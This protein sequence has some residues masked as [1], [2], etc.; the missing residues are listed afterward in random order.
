MEGSGQMVV[1]V[2]TLY[3]SVTTGGSIGHAR[4]FEAAGPLEAN[5]AWV[6]AG[7]AQVGR[8]AAR[9][10]QLQHGVH[11]GLRA[12]PQNR[13]HT[14]QIVV[15]HARTRLRRSPTKVERQRVPLL[16]R[17]CPRPSD[18]TERAR[19]SSGA[20][21]LRWRGGGWADRKVGDQALQPREL[22]GGEVHEAVDPAARAFTDEHGEEV[23]ARPAGRRGK[24]QLRV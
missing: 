7:G 1:W 24:G 22:L 20:E 12:Q 3:F 14:E 19:L 6:S 2:F 16:H 13:Q 10:G 17:V 11:G 21:T 5:L 9:G 8:D 23:E 15:G 4:H 18:D